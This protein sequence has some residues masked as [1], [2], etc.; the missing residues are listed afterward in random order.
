MPAPLELK[1]RSLADTLAELQ[2]RIR[3]A[4]GDASLRTFL[5]QLLSVTGNWERALAQ[6][7]VAGELD[8]GAIAM[9]Q[10]YRDAI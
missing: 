3:S 10:T 5:F 6:L 9:V 7:G 4:P 1:G 2:Q 8:A